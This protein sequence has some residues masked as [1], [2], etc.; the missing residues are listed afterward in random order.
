MQA[1]HLKAIMDV[2]PQPLHTADVYEKGQSGSQIQIPIS[3]KRQGTGQKSIEKLP[4]QSSHVVS[5][6]SKYD[7]IGNRN[8]SVFAIAA[9]PYMGTANKPSG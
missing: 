2:S 9:R 6:A 1:A 4:P 8:N 7:V 3:V 5:Q